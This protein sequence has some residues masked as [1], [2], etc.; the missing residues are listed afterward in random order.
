MRID[1]GSRC[2]PFR[3]FSVLA[4]SG[5]TRTNKFGLNLLEKANASASIS[6][7]SNEGVPAASA[8]ISDL[9][10]AAGASIPE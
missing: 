6:E 8:T 2:N 10:F 5:L 1:K 3:T 4:S 7:M 9:H